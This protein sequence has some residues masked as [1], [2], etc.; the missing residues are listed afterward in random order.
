MITVYVNPP[1]PPPELKPGEFEMK[2]GNKTIIAKL[3][4]LQPYIVEISKKGLVTV[5]F[6]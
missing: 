4:Y 1:P 2:I 6:F 3:S 5:D